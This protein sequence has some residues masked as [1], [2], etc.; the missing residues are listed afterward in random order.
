MKT[1]CKPFSWYVEK[2]RKGKPWA[3]LRFGDGEL[4][5]MFWTNRKHGGGRTKNGDRHTLRNKNLRRALRRSVTQPPV[6]AEYYRALWM[7][8][9][10]QPM[11]RLARDFLPK[12]APDVTWYNAL[13][14]QAKLNAGQGYP[15]IKAIRDRSMPLIVIGPDHLRALGE[16]GVFDY[17]RFVQVPYR[18]AFFDR[19]RILGEAVSAVCE[20]GQ[21]YMITIHAGPASPVIT[22]DLW[23]AVGETCMIMDL[24]SVFDGFMSTKFGG[25]IKGNK[26]LTRKHWRKRCTQNIVDRN[27]GR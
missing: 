11:E 16:V 12:L 13:A 21:P 8:A 27:L 20:A 18:R 4:N 25:P 10:C 15:F 19:D 3:F 24:G 5:G 17:D 7:D 26:P 23:R 22:W 9:N 1:C 14:I 2:V 6:D